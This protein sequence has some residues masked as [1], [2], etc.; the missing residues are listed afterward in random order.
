MM[1]KKYSKHYQLLKNY[2]AEDI[3]AWDAWLNIKTITRIASKGISLG[4]VLNPK[5]KTTIDMMLKK[6]S[7]HSDSDY[8]FSEEKDEDPLEY[9]TDASISSDASEHTYESEEDEF[10]KDNDHKEESEEDSDEEEDSDKEEE[11]D[12]YWN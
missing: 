4:E 6:Y 2:S 12:E 1:L 10:S 11:G 3:C 5:N 9:D 8:I 7:K